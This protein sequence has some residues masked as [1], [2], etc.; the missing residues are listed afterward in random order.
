MNNNI[1]N[2]LNI[3]G[4][5]NKYQFY[6]LIMLLNTGLLSGICNLQ[7]SFLIKY[8]SFIIYDKQNNNE[9]ISDYNHK[10][11]NQSQYIMTK[12]YNTSLH[13]LAYSFDIYCK[14]DFYSSILKMNIFIGGLISYILFTSYPDKNGREK[15]YK[16]FSI[17]SLLLQINLF[18]E[19]N[20]IYSCFVYLFGGFVA[21]SYSMCFSIA[22]EFYND[23][24]RGILIGLLNAIVRLIFGVKDDTKEETKEEE[25]NE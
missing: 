17:L 3:V 19:I 15:I 10:Y 2:L 6:V 5:K 11:C 22:A 25:D 4:N 21:F 20:V 12:I 14:N 13:N 16:I 8:P 9:I 18:F 7:I 24:I 1:Q 23:K